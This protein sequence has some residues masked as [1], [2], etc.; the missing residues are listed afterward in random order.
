MGRG[1]IS[2]ADWIRSIA[3][4]GPLDAKARHC[5][6]E[7]F[8]F[9]PAPEQVE[10][11]S[12]A[13]APAPQPPQVPQAPFPSAAPAPRVTN[14]AHLAPPVFSRLRPVLVHEESGDTWNWEQAELLPE[15]DPDGLPVPPHEPLFARIQ[16]AAI[17]SMVLATEVEEGELDSEKVIDT[18][19]S[20][21]PVGRLPRRRVLTLRRGLQLLVDTGE[22]MAPYA[23]DR[24]ELLRAVQQ[25]VGNE[26][27]EVN[28]FIGSPLRGA[29][30]GPRK[31]WRSWR[32][33]LP[34]TPVVLLSE[35]GIG[36]P[37]LQRERAP[38]GEWLRFGEQVR[39][40]GCPLVAI[41]PYEQVRLPP[42]L[43][44]T[45]TLITWDRRMT[46]L[47][48]RNATRFHGQGGQ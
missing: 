27:V 48:A 32:P 10:S 22:R 26:R 19:A 34:G 14:P 13:L 4:F 31:A 47:A 5:L 39:R 28:L 9:E 17:L 15:E 8:H 24:S 37:L 33:P 7:A 16:Q 6:L 35:L 11:A 21:R 38:L 44:R 18:L 30:W 2:L 23:R 45:M 36:E 1:L 43:R 41:V 12:S 42:A 25:H 40:A 29:G 46:P 3:S 20:G